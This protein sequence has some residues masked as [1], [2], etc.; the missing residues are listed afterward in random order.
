MLCIKIHKSQRTRAVIAICDSNL[1]GK[2]FEDGN[3]QLDIRENFFKDREVSSEEAK[4]IMQH[5]LKEDSTF[6]II[7]KEAVKAAIEAGIITPKSIGKIK[8]IPYTLI[9]L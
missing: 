9:L 7:G 5:H 2:K 6:N 3:K 4:K 1:L 8:N